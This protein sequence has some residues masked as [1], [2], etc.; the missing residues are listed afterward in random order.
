MSVKI[1]KE[2]N[3]CMVITVAGIFSYKDL[4]TI[5]EA[6]KETLKSDAKVNCLILA[7]QFRGWGKEGNWG[8]L[9]F[10]YRSDPFI[11]KIAIVA[12]ERWKDE[13]LMFLGA[14]RRDTEVEHFYP[15]E[16]DEARAWLSEQN[17][18]T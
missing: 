2:S 15:E 18:K 14:G 1:S 16:Q 7:E 3:G 13:L 11:Y 10:M 12:N 8:N 17:E 6:A 5:Q 9:T 4:E